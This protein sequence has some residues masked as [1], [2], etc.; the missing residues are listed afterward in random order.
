MKKS[1]FR[2]Y[3]IYTAV[4]ACFCLGVFFVFLRNGRS[5]VW[6]VDGEPQYL[7]Y[8]IYMGREIRSF[9]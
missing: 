8:L 3:L 5:F 4:F 1:R 6:N 7:P 2:F 9:F